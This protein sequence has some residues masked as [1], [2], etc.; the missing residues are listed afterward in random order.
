MDSKTQSACLPQ[1]KMEMTMRMKILMAFV[2]PLVAALTMQAAAASEHHHT[3]MKARAVP[4]E[5]WWNSYAYD[6]P[7]YRW[8]DR[9][10]SPGYLAGKDEGAMSG[11]GY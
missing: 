1:T 8:D 5:Q 3:R 7:G 4:T 11:A 2:V 6:A 9:Y 10:D